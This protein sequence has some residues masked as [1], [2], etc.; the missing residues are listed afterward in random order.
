MIPLIDRST[1]RVK[2]NP[3]Q[4][5][6]TERKKNVERKEEAKRAHQELLGWSRMDW[7]SKRTKNWR[8]GRR[9]SRE[10]GVVVASVSVSFSTRF[11]DYIYA[12]HIVK[13]RWG[14]GRKRAPTPSIVLHLYVSRVS[15][16]LINSCTLS[17]F[18]FFFFLT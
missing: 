8:R 3:N 13:S 11:A 2:I 6:K 4:K 18:F 16:P 17:L 5:K 12:I 1:T 9:R 14:Q 15:H 7:E 10:G